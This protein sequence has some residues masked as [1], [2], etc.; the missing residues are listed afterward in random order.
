MTTIL[1][2]ARRR[3][4]ILDHLRDGPLDKR[5]LLDRV[6][7]SRSTVDRAVEE[8]LDTELARAVDGGYEATTAGVLALERSRAFDRDADAISTAAPALAPLWKES[9]IDVTFIRGADVSSIGNADAVGLLADLGSSIRNTD[10]IEGTFPQIARPSL[11]G[12]IR[13]RAGAG[14]DVTFTLSRSLFETLASTFPGWL[15]EVA[16]DGNGDLAVGPV[17]EYGLI[18]CRSGDEREAYLFVYDDGR[19][20]AVLRNDGEAAAWAAD[21]IAAVRAGASDC[22]ERIEDLD[23]DAGFTGV[24]DATPPFGEAS[25]VAESIPDEGDERTDGLLASG[26]AIDDGK[27]RTPAF[28]TREA[29]TVAFWMQ[30]T[31]RGAG[32]QILLKWDHLVVALRRGELHGM[33]YDPDQEERRAYTA[34]PTPDIPDGRWQHVAYTYD[35]SRA[36]L[37]VDGER[38]DET[39]D[40]YPLR[41]D[42]IG[43][44][45]GYH[46]RNRDAGVHDPTYEGRLYDAR[47]YEVA[48]SPDAI[49]RLVTATDP[50]AAVWD[51]S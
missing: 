3:S 7:A 4:A 23:A 6:A 45:L 43:A 5:D 18:V 31:D 17:P 51:G 44:A 16:V 22:R 40:D 13:S 32:W 50:T 30:P 28:G 49:D 46:Y 47:L 42:E 41:I 38:V 19:L 27:L 1:H 37:Y 15:R 26:Y 29:C 34:V 2:T 8:L 20:H 14:A 11:L 33:V 39:E 21:R 48:L 9:V 25:A 35:E 36:R 12:P 24:G 10:E